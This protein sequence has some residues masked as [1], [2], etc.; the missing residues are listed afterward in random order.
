MELEGSGPEA[1]AAP[2][3]DEQLIPALRR[4]LARIAAALEAQEGAGG[5]DAAGGED[6]VA[7]ALDGIERVMKGELALGNGDRLPALLPGFVFL[8]ALPLVGQGDGIDLSNRC[9]QL[10]EEARRTA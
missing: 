2:S 3:S 4:T 10:L 5:Q 7:A 1:D 9:G 6:A 8:I